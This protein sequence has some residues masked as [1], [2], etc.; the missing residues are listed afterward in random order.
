MVREIKPSKEEMDACIRRANQ[1]VAQTPSWVD[2]HKPA[3]IRRDFEEAEPLVID[4]DIPK[5][6]EDY[7][8]ELVIEL[9]ELSDDF[10]QETNV[11]AYGPEEVSGI[12][13]CKLVKHPDGEIYMHLQL[14]I[15]AEGFPITG[16]GKS[17]MVAVTRGYLDTGCKMQGKPIYFTGACIVHQTKPP[18]SIADSS[19]G[20]EKK[21]EVKLLE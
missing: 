10:F 4:T 9:E 5:C 12:Q 8:D 16:S 14:R 18:R 15:L 11:L 19:F 2:P 1:V 13:N 6:E 20:A 17:H 3:S 21:Y 7:D